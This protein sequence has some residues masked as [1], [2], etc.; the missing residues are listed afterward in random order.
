MAEVPEKDIENDVKFDG[1]KCAMCKEELTVEKQAKLLHC[2]HSFCQACLENYSTSK[3]KNGGDESK[4]DSNS[5][6]SSKQL[7]FSCAEGMLFK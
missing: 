2:L 6:A 3:S 4:K 5:D 1:A 7:K